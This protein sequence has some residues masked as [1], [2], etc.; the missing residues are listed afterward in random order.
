MSSV[1]RAQAPRALLPDDVLVVI[2]T[3]D[4]GQAASGLI[5]TLGSVP[6]DL[7]ETVRTEIALGL[8]AIRLTLGETPSVL[9]AQL[10]KGGMALGL[11]LGANGPPEALLVLRPGD[12]KAA[13][14]FLSKAGEQWKVV[15][16]GDFLLAGSTGAARDALLRMARAP[17]GRWATWPD[18]EPGVSA[19]S[20]AA[21]ASAPASVPAKTTVDG[22]AAAR[23]DAPHTAPVR[24]YVDLA[25]LRKLGGNQGLDGMAGGGRFALAPLLPA[26]LAAERAS[27]TLRGGSALSL[28]L[29]M[30]S[31]TER[32]A[33]EPWAALQPHDG[34]PR[35]IVAPPADALM[36]VA[37]DRSL[38]ALL[39]EPTKY[40]RP[41]DAT[42]AQAF[43]GVADQLDGAR[44]SFVDDLLGGIVEPLVVCVLPPSSP[45]ESDPPRLAQ[46]SH[47]RTGT[48]HYFSAHPPS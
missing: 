38:R 2:E 37:L 19:G 15:E 42:A 31:H 1:L 48:P 4:A 33:R 5:D 18:A 35:T 6:Q 30:A 26:L 23:H 16:R 36:V 29:Q 13:R 22:A 46:L 34:A 17:Q 44:S 14:A 27:V 3:D 12:A 24:A 21:G 11:R 8:T 28:S 32:R 40:L 39:Q 47:P 45:S 41:E 43:L 9:G 20:G 25:G 10:A 7:P